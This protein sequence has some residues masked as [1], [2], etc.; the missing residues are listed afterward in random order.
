[1]GHTPPN[2]QAIQLGSGHSLFPA[3]SRRKWVFS[4]IWLA[5]SMAFPIHPPV[6]EDPT[7]SPTGSQVIPLPRSNGSNGSN[8]SNVPARQAPSLKIGEIKEWMD[9]LLSHSID[10]NVHMYVCMYVCMYIH[11]LHYTH[12]N[13]YRRVY[14][15]I[16]IYTY[17]YRSTC[18]EA[19]MV[20]TRPMKLVVLTIS[21]TRVCVY[22]YR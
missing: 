1:M 16:Y 6:S 21:T 14:I 3:H 19:D 8:K 2:P 5:Q 11:T 7:G 12:I 17:N 9:E 20:F 22:M 10:I 4:K 15:Y 13:I 18:K